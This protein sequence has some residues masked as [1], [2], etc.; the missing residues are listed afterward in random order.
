MFMNF[1]PGVVG[2]NLTHSC[3][4]YEVSNPY[5]KIQA[6]RDLG[7]EIIPYDEKWTGCAASLHALL[8]IFC[9]EGCQILQN[10]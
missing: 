4:L 3:S 2:N 5:P 7:K 1:L 8:I 9:L 10:T 6:P